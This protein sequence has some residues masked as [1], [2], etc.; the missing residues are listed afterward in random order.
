MV[1]VI[2]EAF[3]DHADPGRGAGRLRRAGARCGGDR[4]DHRSA[5]RHH[6]LPPGPAGLVRLGRLPAVAE[7]APARASRASCWP[8]PSTSPSAIACSPR[9]AAPARP[10]TA[11]RCGSPTG[12]ASTAPS[13]PPA[14]RSGPTPPST[15]T[16][17][18]SARSS[19]QA[20]AIR[21]CGAAALDL[22]FTAAGVYDGF[23]EF[24]L[25]PWDLA[26]GVLLIREAGGVVTDLDGGDGFLRPGQRGGRGAGRPAGAAARR[27]P[28][29]R[30]RRRS[31]AWTPARRGGRRASKPR[32][33]APAA[34]WSAGGPHGEL[35]TGAGRRR[36]ERALLEFQVHP[37]TS[38]RR[39]ATSS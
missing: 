28:A 4:V 32:S 18:R 30:T 20:R 33:P 29:T 26:A 36:A 12:R 34:E 6:Q 3:P 21:R 22:A 5:R 37:R 10:S 25:S 27:S 35:A 9:P 38:A 13:C 23:F 14:I 39:S 24:R 16:S 15:S 31:A 2:R 17:R 7:S 19:C 1:G 11:R 8:G